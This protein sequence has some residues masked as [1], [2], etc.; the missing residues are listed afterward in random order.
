M[1]KYSFISRLSN[2]IKRLLEVSV[3][4]KDY[5][6]CFHTIM[7]N[8]FM[9][10]RRWGMTGTELDSILA[11]S[12]VAL[13]IGVM[14]GLKDIL[15]FISSKTHSSAVK[16]ECARLEN[17]ISNIQKDI[18]DNN[19]TIASSLDEGVK[20]FLRTQNKIKQQKVNDLIS[21]KNDLQKSISK[22]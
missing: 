14:Y 3:F 7:Y 12:V 5:E 15:S 6:E 20:N 13:L 1:Y 22:I 2:W 16:Q 11:V 4:G 19:T 9:W 18:E 10:E 17:D 8:L 21:K